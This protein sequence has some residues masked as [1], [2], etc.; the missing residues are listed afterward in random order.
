MVVMEVEKQVEKQVEL[1][2]EK[3]QYFE[4]DRTQNAL[5][6]LFVIFSNL[7]CLCTKALSSIHL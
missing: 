2:V 6:V 5:D 4:L 1:Q 7:I 3:L